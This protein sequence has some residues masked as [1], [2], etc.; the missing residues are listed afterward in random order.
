MRINQTLVNAGVLCSTAILIQSAR[1]NGSPFGFYIPER[2]GVIDITPTNFSGESVGNAEPSIGVGLNAKYGKMADHAFYGGTPGNGG[3]PV[4]AYYASSGYGGP[5]WLSPG[6]IADGDATLDW[7]AGGTCYLS[8]IPAVTKIKVMR[9]P[10]PGTV[11]FSEIAAATI[12]KGAWPYIPDQPWIRVVNVTNADHIFV[13]YNDLSVYPGKTATVRYSFDS[14]S[15]WHETVLEK[16]A[17]TP[18]WDSPNV[19]L[20]ISADGKT[21]YAMFLRNTNWVGSTFGS[22]YKGEVVLTRDDGSG[23]TGFSAL[24]A[25]GA[26]TKVAGGIVLPWGTTMLRGQRFGTGGSD[27]AI[28]PRAPATV[29]VAYV[30]VS[31]GV[32]VIRVCRSVNS[33]AVFSQV[34]S[35]T[36]ACYPSLAVT[37]DG[38]VGLLYLLQNG[39]DL[40]V[41]FTKAYSGN[42]TATSMVDSPLAKFPWTSSSWVGDYFQLRAINY[43]FFGTFCASGDPQLSHFPSGVYYQRNVNVN[44]VVKNHFWLA[45]TGNVNLADLSGN[46]VTPSMD[47][48]VFYDYAPILRFWYYLYFIPQLYYDPGDPFQ[49]IAHLSWPVLPPTEPQFQLYTTPSLGGAWTLATNN[50]IIQTNG[51]NLANFG[52][53]PGQQFYR[54]Q[55]DVAAGQFQL[56]AAA[57]ANGSLSPSGILTNSGLSSQT[58]TATASNNFAVSKWYLD[59][60]VIQTNGASFTVSNINMEHTLIVTF[61]AFND[62]AVAVAEF[63]CC[64]GPPETYT[65]NSYVIAIENNGVN[66]LT[67]VTM[68]NNLD[69]AAAFVSASTTQ[70]SVAHSGSQ[71]T[72]AIGTLGPGSVATVTIEFTAFVAGTIADT[73]NVTCNEAE[74]DLSNNSVVDYITF[75]DPVII[76]NQ[77]ASL[78]APATG[79]ATFTV[80]VTGSPPFTYQWFFNGTNLINNATNASLTLT[81][82]TSSQS[83][84][85]SVTVLQIRDPESIEGETSQQATLQVQ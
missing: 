79:T 12:T 13:G 21:V 82:L 49:G 43:D 66:T 17:T 56:F 53:T 31:G 22:D 75:I 40:E 33:G 3:V 48:F 26:G 59:G 29:Y 34:Y 24:G 64:D 32:P 23:G 30:E 25:G 80:G 69:S 1:V 58:F 44:G 83:G 14:G 51:Q 2:F 37:R 55:Q 46:Y 72:A 8:S 65:T 10:D 84:N 52:N 73:A 11:A 76:T 71:V 16:V 4:N 74:P 5:E 45:D 78:V 50:S 62:L 70:G 36:D 61:K 6:T 20:A 9:S 19:R 77:P 81:N 54:L 38:T 39:T 67:G 63:P 35:V 41:H 47:P 18:G 85:Y 27:V 60:V 28:N 15:T 57:G 68:T 7:S 42:F